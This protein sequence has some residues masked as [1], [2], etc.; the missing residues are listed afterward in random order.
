MGIAM[1]MIVTVVVRTAMPVAV[2]IVRMPMTSAV[3]VVVGCRLG[4]G[5]LNGGKVSA[6]GIVLKTLK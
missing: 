1:V 2:V 5:R 4:G 3:V 6:H